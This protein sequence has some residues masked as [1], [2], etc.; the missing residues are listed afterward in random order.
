MLQMDPV[1]HC[2]LCHF[3]DHLVRHSFVVEWWIVVEQWQHFAAKH[4]YPLASC[5][6]VL[7]P[8]SVDASAFLATFIPKMKKGKIATTTKNKFNFN[9]DEIQYAAFFFLCILE[10]KM[11]VFAFSIYFELEPKKEIYVQK[12]CVLSYRNKG[13]NTHFEK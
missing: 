13:R 7:R 5:R 6:T 8:S 9:T 1:A 12:I 4:P 11:I 2:W 3:D 10:K